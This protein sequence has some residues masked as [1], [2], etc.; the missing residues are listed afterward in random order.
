LGTFFDTLVVADSDFIASLIVGSWLIIWVGIA[1]L[2]FNYS[3]AATTNE[4]GEEESSMKGRR[5]SFSD[6][7]H[8]V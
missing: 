2:L 5:N 3:R 1:S 6:A 8:R 7:Y 4:G